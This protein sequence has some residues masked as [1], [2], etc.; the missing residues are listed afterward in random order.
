MTAKLPL[1][2]AI[3]T[4]NEEKNLPACLDSVAGLAS[5]IVI[6]DSF[7]T[8]RTLDIARQYGAQVEQQPWPGFIGQ[9]NRA[10]DLCTQEWILGLDA[11]ERLSP[12][13]QSALRRAIETAGDS[14]AGFALNRKAYY[15][16]RWIEHSWYPDW[17]VRVVRRGKA[18]WEGNDLH[19]YLAPVGPTQRLQ[20]DLH[21]YPYPTLQSHLERTIQYARVNADYLSRTGVRA[22]WYHLVLHPVG[23]FLKKI[24]LKGAWLDGMPGIIIAFGT[25]IGV[26][27][28]YAYLWERQN[29][30]REGEKVIRKP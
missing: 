16:G 21:H 19:P 3:V 15:L 7:S 26:F 29:N 8:D 11:D 5:E 6:V 9:K 30:G 10:F 14:V 27:A 12:E 25:L 1:S 24:A 20:G 18:R 2:V 28:K 4:F 22:R 23:A 17:I 13:L